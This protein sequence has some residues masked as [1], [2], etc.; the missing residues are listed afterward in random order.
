MW[1]VCLYDTRARSKQLIGD[2]QLTHPAVWDANRRQVNRRYVEPGVLL[3]QLPE[4]ALTVAGQ[5][6]VRVS[7]D[8]DPHVWWRPVAAA[9]VD[10]LPAE[11]VDEFLIAVHEVV[12]NPMQHGSGPVQLGLWTTADRVVCEVRDGDGG[13]LGDLF[14]GYLPPGGDAARGMGLWVARQL[15]DALAIQSSPSGTTVRLVVLR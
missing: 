3:D 2:A 13:G 5:P 7:V 6:S 14:A 15:T 1:I 11:R 9:I 12:I 4:P 10:G 8:D